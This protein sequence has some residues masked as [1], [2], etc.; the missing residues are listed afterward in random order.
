[1]V[2]LLAAVV[3]APAEARSSSP[4]CSDVAFGFSGTISGAPDE[5]VVDSRDAVSHEAEI[6]SSFCRPVRLVA[7]LTSSD[8]AADLDLRVAWEGVDVA[9]VAS[10][11]STETAILDGRPHVADENAEEGLG[12]ALGTN[13][14]WGTYT[15][16]VEPFQA[17]DTPYELVV[18]AEMK[19]VGDPK[20]A[21]ASKSASAKAKKQRDNRNGNHDPNVVI[22]VVDTG[23]NPYHDEFSRQTYTGGADLKDKPSTYIDEFPSSARRLD[24]ALKKSSYEAAVAA[25]ADTWDGITPGTLYWIPGTKI[26]GAYC[27][28]D[29]SEGAIT[30]LPR[31]ILDDDEVD[32][33]SDPL[34]FDGHGTLSAGVAAG[35]T[36]GSCP[37]CLLVIVEGSAGLN[38]A[39]AQP[40]IDIVTNSWGTIGNLGVPTFGSAHVDPLGILDNGERTPKNTRA[41]VARGQTVLFAAGNGFEDGFITPEPTL[42]SA[43]AGPSWVMTVGAVFKLEDEE[44]PNCDCPDDEGSIIGSGKPV[45]VSSYGLGSIP[46]PQNET[47]DG[48]EDHS[49]TSA[50]SPIVAGVMGDVLLH[51]RTVLDD[52]DGGSRDPIAEGNGAGLL[53]GGLTRAELE[54]ATKNTAEHTHNVWV[55]FPLTAPTLLVPPA[56]AWSQWAIEGWGVVARRTG[57]KAK[58]VV[59]GSAP[60]ADRPMDEQFAAHDEQLRQALWGS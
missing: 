5:V 9:Y 48:L 47:N 7:R 52:K 46:G 36:T 10:P 14:Y 20:T 54:L 26:I 27:A 32:E 4:V 19:P 33:S 51:A 44:N 35:N 57:A 34:A 39:L 45:D 53:Q 23:V 37:R 1:M 59:D 16:D 41:A 21:T 31:C 56:Q 29:P 40:W 30:S 50:A 13:P 3:G 2:A 18:T 6:G 28:G 60:L 58:Q 24:L 25:D 12:P 49:G 17:V 55:S 38:W 8:P 11:F 43:T 22:A 15:F 42:E